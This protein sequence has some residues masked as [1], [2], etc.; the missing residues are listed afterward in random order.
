MNKS[1]STIPEGLVKCEVCG[2]YGGQV[3][4]KDLDWEGSFDKEDADK[5]EEHLTI[6]CLCDGILCRICKT[7]KIHRPISNYYDEESNS[8][9]HIPYFG[10][11]V[12][13]AEC[14]DRK[15]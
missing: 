9:W 2:E 15:R 14:R 5:S 6:S 11:T 4:E 1:Q 8:I 3:M 10:A 7:N 13:C 12:G